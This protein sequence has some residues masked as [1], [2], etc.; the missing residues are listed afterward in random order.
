MCEGSQNNQ[1]CK[2]I[3]VNGVGYYGTVQYFISFQRGDFKVNCWYVLARLY[4]M[5]HVLWINITFAGF[6]GFF[7]QSNIYYTC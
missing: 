4:V 3:N 5:L 7:Q 2:Q 1:K 6:G